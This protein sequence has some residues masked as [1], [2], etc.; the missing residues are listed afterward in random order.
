VVDLYDL[1][2]PTGGPKGYAPWRP[3]HRTAALRGHVIAV[4]DQYRA[5]WPIGPRQTAYTTIGQYGYLKD[6]KHFDRVE[7]VLKRGRR[8][9]AIPWEAVADGWTPDPWAPTEYD[10][11]SDWRHEVCASAENFSRPLLEGQPVVI[12]IWVE[13]AGLAPQVA[14]VAHRYGIKVYPSGGQTVL[15]PRR[16]MA[17]RAV[18]RWL[19]MD[20]VSTLV[21]HVG[22]Y[23]AN[24]VGI[25]RDLE[26]D[27][28]A[29]IATGSVRGGSWSDR[30]LRASDVL[31]MQRVAMTPE[32]VERFGLETDPVKL[33]KNGAVPPGPALPYN[34]QAEALN[35][36]QLE[37]LLVEAIEWNLDMEVFSEAQSRSDIERE[38]AIEQTEAIEVPE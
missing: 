9:G 30:Q 14:R 22:D 34:C 4:L 10:S 20:K 31:S 37:A 18:K 13:T 6:P 1:D 19:E 16:N 12:E 27:V 2:Y 32:V 38:W 8:S 21:L 15:L 25:F 29:F 23:D 28:T 3:D 17:R 36:E 7:Y 11:L 33:P 24:G 5:Y 35:P 26:A